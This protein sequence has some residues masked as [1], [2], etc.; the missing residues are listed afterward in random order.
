[1]KINIKIKKIYFEILVIKIKDNDKIRSYKLLLV[2][3]IRLKLLKTKL[4]FI[5][6]IKLILD[7]GNHNNYLSLLFNK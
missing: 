3:L 2:N 5:K 4:K 1:M 6:F 7:I